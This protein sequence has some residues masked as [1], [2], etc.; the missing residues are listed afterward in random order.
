MY[1]CEMVKKSVSKNMPIICFILVNR[2]EIMRSIHDHSCA[3]PDVLCQPA[4]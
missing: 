4:E 1:A 2:Q 3:V